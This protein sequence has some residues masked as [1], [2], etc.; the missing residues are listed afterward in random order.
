MTIFSRSGWSLP[1]QDEMTSGLQ[2]MM[3][4]KNGI[5]G[6]PM[7]AI[8]ATKMF[9]GVHEVLRADHVRPFKELQAT[10]KRC[11]S[12]IDDWFNFS[13]KNA[14]FENWPARKDD[15]LRQ[16]RSFAQEL[17]KKIDVEPPNTFNPSLRCSSSGTRFSVASSP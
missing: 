2:T 17:A 12:T 8:F 6:C 9:L 16:M 11:V 7:Y 13:S 15:S 1:T 3:E 14:P 4:T 5:K 10:L